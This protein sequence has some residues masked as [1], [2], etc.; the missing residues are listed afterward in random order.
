[1]TFQKGFAKHKNADFLTVQ[2]TKT[3]SDSHIFCQQVI[4][5]YQMYVFRK[6]GFQKCLQNCRVSVGLKVKAIY[7]FDNFSTFQFF[8]FFL[9][10]PKSPWKTRQMALQNKGPAFF[11]VLSCFFKM[12]FLRCYWFKVDVLK[13]FSDEKNSKNYKYGLQ[14]YLTFLVWKLPSCQRKLSPIMA[15]PVVNIES[16]FFFK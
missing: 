10:L 15:H 16:K 8:N 1:M 14:F 12:S 13:T 5:R 11:C 6:R 9:L 3:A 2:A 7:N 4:F